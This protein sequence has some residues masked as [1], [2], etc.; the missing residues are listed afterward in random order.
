MTIITAEI[1]DPDAIKTSIATVAAAVSY[2]GVA[3]NGADANPGPATPTPSHT[4]NVVTDVPQYPTA[5]ASSSAGSYVDGSE[6]VFTGTYGGAAKSRTATVVGTDGNATFVADGPL[7]TVSTVAV[8]A[9]ADTNGAWTFGFTDIGAWRGGSGQ[10]P[11]RL[12]RAHAAGVIKIGDADGH[13]DLTPFA[14]SESQPIAPHRIY[15]TGT[16]VT[17]FTLYR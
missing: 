12:V 17:T 3:L 9:Q 14:E 10:E 15:A 7:D 4:D 16:T 2:T 8:D 5:T 11:A 6:V 1:A 13:V